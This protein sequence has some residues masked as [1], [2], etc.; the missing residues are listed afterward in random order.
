MTDHEIAL[1]YAPKVYFDRNETIP[2]RAVGYT[3]AR[4]TMPSPSFARKMLTVPSQA[5]FAVEYAY[6][7]DY[8]IEHMYDLEHIWVTVDGHGEV[9]GAQA[10]FHGF[11]FNL[12][13]PQIP[14][15][16]VEGRHVAAYCQPGKHAFL[17]EG[18]LFRL[19]P[20]W[21][22]SC[23]VN[24]GGPVLIG[25]PFRADAN[26]GK[27]A[28]SPSEEDHLNSRR[29]LREN[30]AFEPSMQFTETQPDTVE[31]MPWERLRQAIPEW[32][33]AECARLRE[34]YRD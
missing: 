13:A 11:Y 26:G 9:M 10:S 4:E 19:I 34:M 32:V 8:D 16:R 23:N 5:G 22:E 21:F 1:M 14:F 33:N 15:A 27:D 18:Q 24:C 7:W 30:R 3:I 29:F 28:Y 25:G 2:L 6:Y 12:F 31:Y 17:P 20:G